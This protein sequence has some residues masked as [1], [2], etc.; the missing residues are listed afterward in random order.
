M[1][2]EM[3]IHNPL[4]DPNTKSPIYACSAQNGLLPAGAASAKSCDKGFE[5][6]L[7]RFQMGSLGS[8]GSG[9]STAQSQVLDVI[10]SATT[11]LASSTNC[12]GSHIF[13]TSQN[14]AAGL[15]VGDA[16]HNVRTADSILTAFE[17]SLS[18]GLGHQMVLQH[19]GATAKNT[20]GVAVNMD[21]DLAAVQR[22]VQTWSQ[23]GCASG[24]DQELQIP[25]SLLITKPAS[26]LSDALTA[27]SNHCKTVQVSSGDSCS[28]LAAECGISGAKF[29]KYNPNP[30]L[31]SSL[32][33][34][35]SVCCSPGSLPDLSPKPNSDGSCHS[36]T[37]KPGDSCSKLAASHSMSQA[38]IDEY[39]SNTWGWMGCQNGLMAGQTICLSSGTP[40]FPAPISNAVCGPQVP[41][42][43]EPT[44]G[45]NWADLNP[46]PLYACCD[47][48][49]QCGVDP[50]FCTKTDS[51]T[52]APGTEGCI[53][54]CGYKLVDDKAAAQ[55]P[56]TPN[57]YIR[58]GYYEGWNLQRNCVRMKPNQIPTDYTHVHF[59]FGT[60]LSDFT[61]QI[62]EKEHYVFDEFVKM[63]GFKRIVT[64]GGWAFSTDPST[65][66]IFREGVKPA[67]RGTLARK[68]ADFVNT[69]SLDGVDFD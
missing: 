42:T 52:G 18:Q 53:A 17:A 15:Y 51:P 68:V 32:Q 36:Y 33:P 14:A 40:P 50:S 58:V 55:N 26:Q 66:M 12:A 6:T 22:L 10:K 64:F 67:N 41:G 16:I 7:V 1:L 65:Y 11:Y 35:Q 47:T 39:N 48:W 5:Q 38:D 30:K 63:T 19:C 13:G 37:V 2:M 46:C 4:D 60:I 3:T 59:A 31:C 56:P 49:G 54:F 20:F 45:T 8:V 24:F 21:G 44:N 62:N 28:S 57:W 23:G 69:H 9:V 25:G 43:S 29:T 34:G 27:R 61:A